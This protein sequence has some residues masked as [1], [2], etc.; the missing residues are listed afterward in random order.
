MKKSEFEQKY[1]D[2]DVVIS[3]TPNFTHFKSHSDST[4]NKLT[5]KELISYIKMLYHNWSGCDIK[6][7]NVM[8]IA[9]KLDKAL[10]LYIKWTEECDFGYDNIPDEWE[11]Y[12]KE[13]EDLDYREGLKYIALKE[14][15]RELKKL[16]KKRRRI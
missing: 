8:N 1:L 12:E 11:R 4:L 2:E 3:H 13:I 15:E 6:L 14:A 16:N 5:K 10:E 7:S 9:N